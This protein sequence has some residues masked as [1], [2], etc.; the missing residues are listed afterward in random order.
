M[1]RTIINVPIK[2]RYVKTLKKFENFTLLFGKVHLQPVETFCPSVYTRIRKHIYNF[3]WNSLIFRNIRNRN[4]W[5]NEWMKRIPFLST[6]DLSL[7]AFLYLFSVIELLILFL[8]LERK[9]QS[10]TTSYTNIT[11]QRRSDLE[12]KYSFTHTSSYVTS[13]LNRFSCKE[14]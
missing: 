9:T 2:T 7:S 8:S 13:F 14:I 3:L 1:P 5:M 4:E 6:P 10:H 11:P 12:R